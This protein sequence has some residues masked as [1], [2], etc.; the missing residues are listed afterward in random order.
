MGL[1]LSVVRS[2]VG[3]VVAVHELGTD[4]PT[5]VFGGVDIDI[6]HTSRERVDQLIEFTGCN[7][8]SR[9]PDDV[10][11]SENANASH[12]ATVANAQRYICLYENCETQA[13]KTTREMPASLNETMALLA[14]LKRIERTRRVIAKDCEP[15]A[16]DRTER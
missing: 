6:G 15:E 9:G 14:S 13:A 3:L 10:S 1:D 11:W 16:K 2:R 12:A 5:R 8:L 4:L 7:S